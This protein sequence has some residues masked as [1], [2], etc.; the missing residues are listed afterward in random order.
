MKAHTPGPWKVVR[1]HPD[2]KTAK[3]YVEVFP[4]TGGSLGAWSSQSICGLFC[5][6]VGGV[7]EANAALIAAAPD[8]LEALEKSVRYFADL[9]GSEWIGED[10]VGEKD[11]RQRAKA[12]HQ[13]I[14]TAIAKA[15]GTK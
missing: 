2:P 7:Q 15:K 10:G 8:L 14:F 1:N 13:I 11:M 5:A 9:N 4:E 3:S 6:E 12:L